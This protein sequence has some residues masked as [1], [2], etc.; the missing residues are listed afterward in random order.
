MSDTK[1]SL[2][3]QTEEGTM[4]RR[5]SA[6]RFSRFHA[7]AIAIILGF[8]WLATTWNCEHDHGGED[9]MDTK[10]P[11]EVHIMSKCPDA[12]DCL[13]KLVLPAMQNVSDKVDFRL[14]FI[15]K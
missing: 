3:P 9:E 15:G 5:P 6:K 8:F 2:L 13:Q 1:E 12:R 4:R 14:S 7:T 10:V 11:L